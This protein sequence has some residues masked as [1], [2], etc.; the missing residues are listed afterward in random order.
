MLGTV[1]L[2]QYRMT[3]F[4]ELQLLHHFVILYFFNLNHYFTPHAHLFLFHLHNL[5]LS[6]ALPTSAI[7]LCPP[8][9]VAPEFSFNLRETLRSSL[10]MH[11]LS[12]PKVAPFPLPAPMSAVSPFPWTIATTMTLTMMVT[13]LTLM[14][15]YS[16]TIFTTT[17]K[18]KQMEPHSLL[19][20]LH[21]FR[22]TA[23]KLLLELL[24]SAASNGAKI[25][26][27]A[28]VLIPMDQILSLIT[29]KAP[30]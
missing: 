12:I 8:P 14:F 19:S 15:Q 18:M 5:F 4:T 30:P 26:H 1:R 29:L 25:S 24:L 21:L 10:Q 16:N 2:R 17:D 7:T 23:N 3:Y 22:E 28:R 13:V 20:P 27:V 9:A 11:I 6:N